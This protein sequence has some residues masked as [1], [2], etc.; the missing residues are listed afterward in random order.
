MTESPLRL[1]LLSIWLGVAEWR[2]DSSEHVGHCPYHFLIA[3]PCPEWS[4]A[5]RQELGEDDEHPA[6]GQHC[7]KIAKY[8]DIT[9]LQRRWSLGM[10]ANDR[11]IWK[12]DAWRLG[13][14][15][16]LRDMGF[17]FKATS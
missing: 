1:S 3:L 10:E 4:P 16:A 8:G 12:T 5:Q 9:G 6:R 11:A 2:S 14:Q 17:V 15:S 13:A 7:R